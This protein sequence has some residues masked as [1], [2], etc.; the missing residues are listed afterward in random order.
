MLYS[1]LLCQ[2]IVVLT[3][4]AGYVIRVMTETVE[5]SKSIKVGLKTP[6]GKTFVRVLKHR[7]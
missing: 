7:T 4:V 1:Q 2:I 5:V 6:F 3:I